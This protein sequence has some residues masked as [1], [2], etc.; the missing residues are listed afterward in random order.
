[1]KMNPR[2]LAKAMQRM[3]I[4]QHEVEAVEVVIRCPDK[5]I[6]ISNPQ[7]ARVNMMGQETW[8][9]T[10]NASERALS[11]EPEIKDEDIKT[12][13]DQTG[14]SKEKALDAIKAANGD[15][16]QAILDLSE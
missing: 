14:V 15:L 9:V 6:V 1:M 12:V 10:G 7:V 4:Q 11:S 2:D 3:G 13:M 8:Q 5:E 16:A